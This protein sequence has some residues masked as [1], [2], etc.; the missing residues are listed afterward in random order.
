MD[1]PIPGHDKSNGYEEF[2]EDFMR[3]RNFRIGPPTVKEWARSL[4]R[5]ASVLDLGC[6]FGLPISQVL[7]DEGFDV[8]GVDASHKMIHAFRERFPSAPAE[9]AAA[10]DSAFFD[11]VFEGIVAWGLIFLLPEYLQ[12]IVIAKAA[13]ALAPG[14]RFLFTALEKRLTWNDSIT[15]REST[16][17]GAPVY[18]D[19][20]QSSGLILAGHTT[21]EGEN[22]YYFAVKPEG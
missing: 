7:V 22:F 15:G 5:G 2:A 11:R 8:H 16:S 19:L 4:A 21:D 13:K 12:R 9:H 10:E 1:Q 14:G 6:G 20:L 3:A 17:L 18:E